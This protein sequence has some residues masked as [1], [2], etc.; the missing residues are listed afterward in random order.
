VDLLP[1]PVVVFGVLLL[2]LAGF[3]LSERI[4]ARSGV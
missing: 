4:E 2:S 1:A 3:R